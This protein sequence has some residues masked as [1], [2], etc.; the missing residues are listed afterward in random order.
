MN[1]HHAGLTGDEPE[2]VT[3]RLIHASDRIAK[4]LC[5][6]PDVTEVNQVCTEAAQ[7]LE[8]ELAELGRFVGEI[9]NDVEELASVLHIEVLPSTVYTM[10]A[11]AIQEALATPAS[12]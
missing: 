1:C 4:L 7:S 6:I 8:I 3:A 2:A 9:E 10:I 12:T 11:Q 5:E